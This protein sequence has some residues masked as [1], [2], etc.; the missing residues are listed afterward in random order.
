MVNRYTAASLT[1]PSDKFI[2]ISAL[3]RELH[4]TLGTIIDPGKRVAYLAGLWT[5]FLENQLLWFSKCPQ[6]TTRF[7]ETGDLTA[8]SWSWAS[9]N[10]PVDTDES[11]S[12]P[13]PK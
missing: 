8:P 7:S 11:F 1:F 5:L 4:R 6:T 9:L 10:G 2:A 3:A 13:V 12:L